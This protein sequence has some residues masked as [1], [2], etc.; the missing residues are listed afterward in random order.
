MWHIYLEFKQLSSSI[1]WGVMAVQSEARKWDF[2][3]RV[4]HRLTPKV[5]RYF[6]HDV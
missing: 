1:S 6:G 4:C 5:L 2:E 3:V